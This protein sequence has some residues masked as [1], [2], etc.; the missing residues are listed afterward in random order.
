MLH[1]DHRDKKNKRIEVTK[2]RRESFFQ[3][4]HRSPEQTP[5]MSSLIN[6]HFG[7]YI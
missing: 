7:D 5:S 3:G 2:T 1:I 4:G 6:G